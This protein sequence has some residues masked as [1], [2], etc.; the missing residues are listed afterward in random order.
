VISQV[1]ENVWPAPMF[2]TSFGMPYGAR[3]RH[4]G[5]ITF[6]DGSVSL[7]RVLKQSG[8]IV[9]IAAPVSL[10]KEAETQT[11]APCATGAVGPLSASVA[12]GGV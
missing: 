12:F 9:V 3:T 1:T 2:T 6:P 4:G 10:V 8:R 5:S 7:K 11:E